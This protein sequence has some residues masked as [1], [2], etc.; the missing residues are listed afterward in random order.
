LSTETALGAKP[1]IFQLTSDK[2]LCVACV[3]TVLD[4]IL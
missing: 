3:H 4:T 1:G 2:Y